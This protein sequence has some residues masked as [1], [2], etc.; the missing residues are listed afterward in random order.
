STPTGSLAINRVDF[1]LV[2]VPAGDAGPERVIAAGGYNEGQEL[3]PTAESYDLGAGVWSAAGSLNEPRVRAIGIA[4]PDGTVAIIGGQ[5]EQGS[6][7][8]TEVLGPDN[9]WTHSAEMTE[10]RD[11]AAAAL[12]PNGRVLTA[13]GFTTGGFMGLGGGL[14][15]AELWSPGG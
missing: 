3:N 15:S 7:S 11:R 10:G 12:L 8:S 13:G 6:L 2:A 14:D 1:T 5:G 9:T 4:L